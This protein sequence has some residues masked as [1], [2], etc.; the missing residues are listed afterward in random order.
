MIPE[1]P[2]RSWAVIKKGSLTLYEPFTGDKP[3]FAMCKKRLGT[4][5]LLLGMENET[6]R[7]CQGDIIGQIAKTNIARGVVVCVGQE[8]TSTGGAL[9]M[10]V[11]DLNIADSEI[12]NLQCK[13]NVIPLDLFVNKRIPTRCTNEE[14]K[15]V[16]QGLRKLLAMHKKHVA[17]LAA[18]GAD[19]LGDKA[20]E[21]EALNPL[22]HNYEAGWQMMNHCHQQ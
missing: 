11:V 15:T 20:D 22:A 17:A 4:F 13:S 12:S 9:S 16:E 6:R 2:L 19:R 10:F 21:D 5:H 7:I 3:V 18:R 8:S 14:M 1:T